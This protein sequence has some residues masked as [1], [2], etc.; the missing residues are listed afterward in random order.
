MQN[1]MEIN[2]VMFKFSDTD[3]CA[4]LMT[5]GYEP[6]HIEVIKQKRHNNKIKVYIHFEGDKNEFI[7][8]QNKYKDNEVFNIK[9]NDFSIIK[10]KL[11]KMI[12]DQINIFNCISS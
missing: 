5:L 4:Y 10:Q 11:K 1:Q 6:I 2:K 12:K 8:I 3:L 7:N 9:L